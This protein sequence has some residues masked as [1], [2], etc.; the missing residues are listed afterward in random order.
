[1]NLHE[2][3]KR[4]LEQTQDCRDAINDFFD[5]WVAIEPKNPKSTLKARINLIEYVRD[6]ALEGFDLQMQ[7][8]KR[9]IKATAPKTKRRKTTGKPAGGSE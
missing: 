6:T 5:H 8:I 4:A 9:A 1:M 7:K 3:A 2:D